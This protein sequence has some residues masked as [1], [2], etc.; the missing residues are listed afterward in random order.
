MKKTKRVPSLKEIE[1]NFD[2]WTPVSREEE[3]KTLSRIQKTKAK[4]EGKINTRIN[5]LD[6]DGLKKIATE[7]NIPYQTLLGHII[8]EYVAGNLVDVKEI[9]KIFPRAKSKAG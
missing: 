9:Q 1:A 4:K 6:L 3:L 8:H 5:E 2:Q 7:K